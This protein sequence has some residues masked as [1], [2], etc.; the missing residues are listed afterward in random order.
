MTIENLIATL[1]SANAPQ[2]GCDTEEKD[3]YV[4]Q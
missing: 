4:L 2:C 3:K 1:F